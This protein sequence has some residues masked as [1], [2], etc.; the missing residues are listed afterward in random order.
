MSCIRVLVLVANVLSVVLG[1]AWSAATDAATRVAVTP[2]EN[3]LFTGLLLRF[4]ELI[5]V[6]SPEKT[7]PPAGRNVAPAR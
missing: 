5:R 2:T 3:I 6:L 4:P 7:L 1:A